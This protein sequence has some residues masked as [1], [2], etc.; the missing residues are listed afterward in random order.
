[1]RDELLASYTEGMTLLYVEDDPVGGAIIQK[2][3]EP[4]FVTVIGA[5]NGGEGLRLFHIHHPDI[6][7]T[8]LMMPLMDGITMLREIR[9]SD[10][11][12]P[13]LLMTASLEHTDLVAAINLGVSKFLAKPLRPDLVRQTVQSVAREISMERLLHKARSQEVELLRYRDRYNSG[14]E[15]LARRKERHI[16]RNLL[17]SLYLPDNKG[18]GWLVDMV[19]QPKD[20]MSGDSYTIRHNH[21]GSVLVFLADA[22]GHGLSASVT[23]MLT[24]SFFNHMVDGCSC[25]PLNFDHLANR[26]MLYAGRNLLEDE[27]FSCLIIQLEPAHNRVQLVSCGM[28]PL[29]LVRNGVV[30]RVRGANPPITSFMEKVTPQEFSLDGVSDILMSTD[31]LYDAETVAGSSY[32][33]FIAE[34]LLATVTASALYN[35]FT[36]RCSDNNDDDLTLIRLIGTVDGAVHTFSSVGTLCGISE[37]Q[38]QAIGCLQAHGAF[39]DR[40]DALETALTEILLNAFEHGCLHIGADKRRLILTGEYD[41]LVMEAKPKPGEEIN[42]ILTLGSRNGTLL[43]WLEITDPGPGRPM[44]S[45]VIKNSDEAPCGRGCAIVRRSVDLA[46]RSP[47]GNNVFISQLLEKERL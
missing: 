36:Q 39:G 25:S 38:Q 44:E 45:P 47:R 6:I 2:I 3:L 23:S 30:E 27:V 13:V 4:Y 34:D 29:L 32:R 19:H 21:D 20:I 8:D 35:C 10:Q 42:V 40:L 5:V 14:Q 41:D 7:I 11:K 37:L 43:A 33:D 12:V 9:K 24:T 1:M 16:V 22:M 18:G 15:E 46:R 26:T 31:G 28:P 17:D